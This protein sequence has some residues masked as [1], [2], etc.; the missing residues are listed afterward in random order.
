M[1]TVILVP[2]L[3]RPHRV[4]P[5]IESIAAATTEP[6]RVLFVA[7]A[8]DQ[9]ER[10]AL[11]DA[12]AEVLVVPR[13]RGS[14][15][16]KINDGYRST[17]EPYLFLAADDLQFHSGWLSAALAHMTGDVRV[18]GTND[19]YNPRV[20]AGTHSTHTLVRRSYC[21]SPGATAD[22]EQT[23]LC[24]QYRHSFT[25]DELIGVARA[26]GV[27]AHAHD[28]VVEHLHPFAKKAP[29]DATYN[30]GARH[31]RRDEKVHLRRR[32]AWT[33]ASSSRPSEIQAGAA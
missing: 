24:E 4:E 23:V 16:C 18:V 20:L 30:L 8:D 33:S 21:H 25:D 26:R 17:T 31:V 1:T 3:D 28:S 6:H 7:S 27:Y 15:P 22:A 29:R 9:A 10:D 14:Y 5:L 19:L 2:V 11:Y 12:R 32:A 13:E